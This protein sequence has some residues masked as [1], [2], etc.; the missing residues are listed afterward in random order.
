MTKVF[1]KTT[2][3]FLLSARIHTALGEVMAGIHVPERVIQ[4][5]IWDY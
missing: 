4:L 2:I 5:C 3:S 1:V